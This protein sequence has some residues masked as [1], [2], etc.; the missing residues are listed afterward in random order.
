M[1]DPKPIS[2][3]YTAP[4]DYT[5]PDPQPFVVIGKVPS[6]QLP[7]SASTE[8]LA[9]WK[10]KLASDAEHAKIALVGDSTSEGSSAA[11]YMY[12]R[13]RTQN[14][15][16]GQP[17]EDMGLAGR[18]WF[19]DGVI[20]S[21]SNILQS[22][23]ANFTAADVGRSLFPS[24]TSQFTTPTF[25]QSVDSATQ[26]RMSRNASQT[27][28]GVG[29]TIGRA[30]LDHGYSGMSLEV[31]LGDEA[32]QTALWDDE[33]DLVIAS[34]LI[35]DAR[36]GQMTLESG[37]ASLTAMIELIQENL[38][39]A[40]IALRTPNPMLT[41]N[42]GG[43]NYVRESPSGPINTAGLAQEYT[44][45]IRRCY[46]AVAGLYPNVSI[47][48]VGADVFGTMCRYTHPLMADQLHPSADYRGGYAVIAD[49]IADA[50]GNTTRD[51]RLT[52]YLASGLPNYKFSYVVLGNGGGAGY[53]DLH[54]VIG[55]D[56]V[57]GMDLAQI[58]V[59]STFSLITDAADSPISLAG[60]NI[61]RPSGNNIRITGLSPLNFT[62][63]DGRPMMLVSNE[64]GRTPS[65]GDRQI[66]N[67]NLPSITAGA[68]VAHTVTVSGVALKTAGVIASPGDSFPSSG[69]LLMGCYA[70]AQDT[71]AIILHNPTG[72]TIDLGS[73]QWA[74]WVIR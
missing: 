52:N 55:P 71:V 36:L 53:V 66:V 45:L 35:N 7:T 58:P 31:W 18:D 6:G 73:E 48:D 68:T 69:L 63:T 24:N 49:Y 28:T 60:K 44:D 56:H 41:Q 20:T 51:R 65:T 19:T 21:G 5:G 4:E 26:V 11:G 34:W 14:G 37:V 72:G 10:R 9:R 57:A 12:H 32:R 13:L 15:V 27:A 64:N 46:F 61:V 29:F 8:P 59:D 17:L 2:L 40:D 16:S 43:L 74:F 62:G 30:I 54:R 70:T 1:A 33:P 22:A 50:I 39:G 47:I 25:V 38:P 23:T 3:T 42:V 67:V